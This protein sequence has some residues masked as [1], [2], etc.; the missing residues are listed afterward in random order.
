MMRKKRKEKNEQSLRGLWHTTNHTTVS[1]IE[2]PERGGARR[3]IEEIMV[4]SSQI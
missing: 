3:V 1:M 4:T 2:I